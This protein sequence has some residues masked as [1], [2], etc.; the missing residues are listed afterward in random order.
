MK[1][2]DRQRNQR[3]GAEAE[4]TALDHLSRAGLRLVARNY[5]CRGGEIDLIM[6][7]RQMLVFV[8]V[9][10]RSGGRFASA[11]ESVDAKKQRRIT[12]AAHHYLQRQPQYR[13]LPCRFDVVAFDPAAQQGPPLQPHWI[14]DAFHSTH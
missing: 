1:L 13:D 10:Y 6:R 14:Q 12:T 7:D 9:R 2:F 8:E 3:I 11:A 4:A 5:R